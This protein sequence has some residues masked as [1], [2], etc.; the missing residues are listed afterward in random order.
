MKAMCLLVQTARPAARW[1]LQGPSDVSA[2]EGRMYT[3]HGD[4]GGFQIQISIPKTLQKSSG[5]SH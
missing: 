1:S 5:K 2:Y 4:S 3:K